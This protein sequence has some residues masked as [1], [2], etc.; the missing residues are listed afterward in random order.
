MVALKLL[1]AEATMI[2]PTNKP[3]PTGNA[4]IHARHS[5]AEGTRFAMSLR[6]RPDVFLSRLSLLKTSQILVNPIHAEQELNVKTIMEMHCALV[7]MGKLVILWFVAL[8]LL[9]VIRM[10][11]DPIP[12][13][14]KVT[15]VNLNV[16]ACLDSSHPLF[17]VEAVNLT[18]F[19]FAFLGL[20]VSTLTAL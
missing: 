7:P 19:N 2:V 4:S 14:L 3:V 13:A 15:E 9:D 17:L 10:L 5:S 6:I 1:D 18:L 16:F 11:V 8:T 12:S 20:A